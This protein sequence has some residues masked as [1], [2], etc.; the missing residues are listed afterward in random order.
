MSTT[1]VLYDSSV[2]KY[3]AVFA[4]RCLFVCL[5]HTEA[6]WRLNTPR[7]QTNKIHVACANVLHYCNF[8]ALFTMR[9]LSEKIRTSVMMTCISTGVSGITVVYT[10]KNKL[11]VGE[12][13]ISFQ[14]APGR[15]KTLRTRSWWKKTQSFSSNI[16]CIVFSQIFLLYLCNEGLRDIEKARDANRDTRRT[17][18]SLFQNPP[19]SSFLSIPFYFLFLFHSILEIKPF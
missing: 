13:N 15:L 14:T 11:C 17:T 2:L 6:R 1:R 4:S 5:F 9:F 16:W 8:C 7:G 18:I 10:S 3:S 12:E 19:A